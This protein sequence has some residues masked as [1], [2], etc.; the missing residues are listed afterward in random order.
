M[1]ASMLERANE[2]AAEGLAKRY[3]QQLRDARREI[4]QLRAALTEKDADVEV[5]RGRKFRLIEAE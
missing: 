2:L 4:A 5:A 1:D 3:Y